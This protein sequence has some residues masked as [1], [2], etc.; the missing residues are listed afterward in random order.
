MILCKEN[1]SI[2]FDN[3]ILDSDILFLAESIKKMFSLYIKKPRILLNIT[4]KFDNLVSLLKQ[5]ANVKIVKNSCIGIFTYITHYGEYDLGIYCRDKT[6]EHIVKFYSGSG[7]PLSLHEFSFFENEITNQS[8]KIKNKTYSSS[9]FNSLFN[10]KKDKY[11]IKWANKYTKHLKS[12]LTNKF[13]NIKVVTNN[14]IEN[15]FLSKIF[16]KENALYNCYCGNAIH[17]YKNNKILN[18]KNFIKYN[19]M[20]GINLIKNENEY[21]KYLLEN[22]KDYLWIDD[23]CY[24]IKNAFDFENISKIIYIVNNIL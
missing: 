1:S 20:S 3:N 13:Q 15:Y 11:I 24:I 10:N 23:N 4:P 17:I 19:S 7:Y 5:Y 9:D 8:L 16:N 22:K 2:I 14:K 21:I 6:D 18:I 12:Q